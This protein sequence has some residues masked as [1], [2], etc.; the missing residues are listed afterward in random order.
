MGRKIRDVGHRRYKQMTEN[1]RYCEVDHNWA[2]VKA[3]QRMMGLSDGYKSH[4][5]VGASRDAMIQAILSRT[6]NDGGPAPLLAF[7]EWCAD[8]PIDSARANGFETRCFPVL[9]R[10]SAPTDER[11]P[12]GDGHK[13]KAKAIY[14]ESPDR[15]GHV[16][17][18]RDID[19][20]VNS[21][22][23][24][25]SISD[26]RT[27]VDV[28]IV[29]QTGSVVHGMNMAGLLDDSYMGQV[30]QPPSAVAIEQSAAV[31]DVVTLLD[32][33]RI[34]LSKKRCNGVVVICS[35]E[36]LAYDLRRYGEARQPMGDRQKED[37]AMFALGLSDSEISR[38][39]QRVIRANAGA[40]H[41]QL[42]RRFDILTGGQ[43]PTTAK[44]VV[45]GA[46]L[47]EHLALPVADFMGQ[48]GMDGI[49]EAELGSLIQD[50]FRRVGV[51]TRL[52]NGV[53]ESYIICNALQTPDV[54]SEAVNRLDELLN[55]PN[56]L[57]KSLEQQ[58]E[59]TIAALKK[60]TFH[61]Q[62]KGRS[63]LELEDLTLRTSGWRQSGGRRERIAIVDERAVR[64]GK[65]ALGTLVHE[66]SEPV[67]LEKAHD[68]VAQ[69]LGL[70]SVPRSR[71]VILGPKR[72]VESVVRAALGLSS[73]EGIRDL[74]DMGRELSA[75][76]AR[77]PGVRTTSMFGRDRINVDA[78]IARVRPSLK[79]L[80]VPDPWRLMGESMSQDELRRIHQACKKAGVL[81]VID[82]SLD[83]GT[84]GFEARNN[85]VVDELVAEGGCV[86]FSDTGPLVAE[87]RSEDERLGMCVLP[88]EKMAAACAD[89]GRTTSRIDSN[90]S[91]ASLALLET[92]LQDRSG[93]LAG[94]RDEMAR[95]LPLLRRLN[96]II[97]PR[98]L[99]NLNPHF[100]YGSTPTRKPLHGTKDQ[101]RLL[102]VGGG[103]AGIAVGLEAIARGIP[104]TIVDD[105]PPGADNLIRSG[106]SVAAAAQFLPY[107]A[108]SDP[109]VRTEI[110]RRVRMSRTT[111]GVLSSNPA[112]SGVLPLANIELLV[113]GE[114]WASEFEDAMKTGAIR[115]DRPIHGTDLGVP[116]EFERYYEFDGFS[117][118]TPHTL[119][120]LREA[121]VQAGGVIE[122]RTI[123]PEEVDRWDGPVVIAA[124]TRAADF[125]ELIKGGHFIG[126]SSIE[127]GSEVPAGRGG[128]AAAISGGHAVVLPRIKPN[129]QY[130]WVI[131]G[132]ARP[133]PQYE[134]PR[135]KDYE[136]L[137]LDA[138][139]MGGANVGSWTTPGEQAFTNPL[140]Y[141]TGLRAYNPEGVPMVRRE[142]KSVMVSGLEGTGWT[143]AFGLARDAVDMACGAQ[144]QL[145]TSALL[146]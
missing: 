22:H 128:L 87:T 107:V 125:S 103:I 2:T 120:F 42:P 79:A 80:I 57:Y 100:P 86:F 83:V 144:R 95:H 127:F 124:G 114:R 129:G 138:R 143:L 20:L 31:G 41:E 111:Y 97:T 146:A 39:L 53:R 55:S 10:R 58:P 75:P 98:Q 33:G 45:D 71:S 133:N 108:S 121:F 81:L 28:T 6:K 48:R 21:F 112:R 102:V 46:M 7:P 27:T 106:I 29:D 91:F 3:A 24:G 65:A 18:R 35:S 67:Y 34:T 74:A 15:L 4:V 40:F 105:S 30:D 36:T 123:T 1:D 136:T 25:G 13:P 69:L 96:R 23:R 118:N 110:A 43:F 19:S 8:P 47:G 50:C 119:K 126:G 59:A 56:G 78:V 32:L 72:R 92:A 109:K 142:G 49:T 11:R 17:K 90:R 63:E 82:R 117:I 145:F 51:L 113:E 101:K 5:V 61:E 89:V 93:Y 44:R 70:E 84:L 130:T 116:A 68:S 16:Q 64:Q 73:S 14:L 77:R 137:I 12:F 88:D 122:H 140:G 115:M 139:G 66:R 54:F 134:H 38:R 76:S 131:G 141:R 85:F 94:M 62:V 132:G 104:V 99:P 37:V 52:Q 135:K 60:G 9:R 26:G